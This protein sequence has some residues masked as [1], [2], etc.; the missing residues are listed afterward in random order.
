MVVRDEPGRT[1]ILL[2]GSLLCE[3]KQKSEQNISAMT[4]MYDYQAHL[5]QHA[6]KIAL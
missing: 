2:G 1:D 5:V 6:S 4:K 3:I